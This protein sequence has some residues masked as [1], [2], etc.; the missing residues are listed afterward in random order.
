MEE[1]QA[2]SKCPEG[3][4]STSKPTV[5]AHIY[6]VRHGETVANREGIL[7]GVSAD[8]PLTEDGHEQAHRTGHFLKDDLW[9]VVLTS[10][11][12][13]AVKVRTLFVQWASMILCMP[14][15]YLCSTS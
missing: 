6:F 5:K 4:A 9:D 7:Q 2:E 8:Y 15:V 14:S 10:D 12:P 11:L 13:R 3:G 1:E